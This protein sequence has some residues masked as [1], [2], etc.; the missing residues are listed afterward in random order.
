MKLASNLRYE[1]ESQEEFQRLYLGE[2]GEDRDRL[3]QCPWLA[4]VVV[5]NRLIVLSLF[6]FISISPRK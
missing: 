5:R 4:L 6:G 3:L 2:K 1:A